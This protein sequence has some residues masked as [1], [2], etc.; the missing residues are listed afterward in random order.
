MAREPRKSSESVIQAAEAAMP[1]WKAVRETS[2]G[3]SSRSAS[4]SV[5]TSSTDVSGSA[6]AV[7]PTTEELKSKYLGVSRSDA[8]NEVE[9]DVAADE[10]DTALVEMESGPL[11]KTVAVSRNSKKLIWSQG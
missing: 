1:G 2:L 11:K 6:D 5:D 4:Y 7:M 10:A 8:L 9:R 3:A